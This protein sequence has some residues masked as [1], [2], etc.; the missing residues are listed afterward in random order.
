MSLSDWP[1]NASVRGEGD[2]GVVFTGSAQLLPEYPVVVVVVV[3][4]NSRSLEPQ[5][6]LVPPG[7]NL[8]KK[9]ESQP[10]MKKHTGNVPLLKRGAMHAGKRIHQSLNERTMNK[11]IQTENKWK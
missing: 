5:P 7:P 2:E 4:E 10:V 8:R 9:A 3:V 11:Y 6:K 1:V